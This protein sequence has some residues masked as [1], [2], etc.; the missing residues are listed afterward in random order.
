[1]KC[2]KCN[3]E[4]ETGSKYCSNCGNNLNGSGLSVLW[5][6]LGFFI[7]ILG[8]VLFLVWKDTNKSDS[9]AAG[10]G[11]LIRLIINIIFVI[12]VL[13]MIFGISSNLFYSF[14]Y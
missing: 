13:I 2:N 12:I 9:K 10:I 5:G 8:L 4:I 1:M 7:P 11:A 3:A 14:L 6:L